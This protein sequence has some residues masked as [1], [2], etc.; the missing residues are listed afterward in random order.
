[1]LAF[2][3]DMSVVEVLRLLKAQV[4]D[5]A[6]VCN[7]VARG[8]LCQSYDSCSWRGHGSS[9]ECPQY[10]GLLIH[11]LPRGFVSRKKSL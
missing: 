1:M 10:Y 4:S 8:D 7:A 5:L 2:E 3:S 6:R 9:Q 11:F